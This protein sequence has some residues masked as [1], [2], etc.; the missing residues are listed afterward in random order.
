MTL[1]EV[2]REHAFTRGLGESQIDT[3]AALASEVTFEENETI[4]ENAQRSR[5]FFLVISGS[6]SV[7]LRTP[8]YAVSVQA[9]GAGQAFGWSA[10]L[11]NHDTMFQVR[12]REHTKTLCLDGTALRDACHKDPTLG[13][14]VLQRALAVVAERVRATEIRFAEMCG[15]RA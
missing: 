2:L 13:A 3:L 8:A 15:V 11:D 7:E 9:V 4:L 14:E 12:T 5:N 10:L 1:H 6:V